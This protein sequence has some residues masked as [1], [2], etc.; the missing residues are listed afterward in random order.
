MGGNQTWT[1]NS[2]NL[3]TVGAAVT[4]IGN[5]TPY[6]LTV[7]GSG[8]TSFSG[9]ISNGGTTGTTALTM[10]GTGTLTLSAANTYTATTTINSGTLNLNF[11]AAGAPTSNIISSSSALAMSGGTLNITGKANV[12]NV[13]QNFAGLT[14]YGGA[15]EITVA[16]NAT[17]SKVILNLTS[18]TR[19]VGGTVNFNLPIAGG[20]GQNGG[21][22]ITETN[23]SNTNGILG[24][25]ATVGGTDWAERTGGNILPLTGNGNYQP[26][27]STTLGASTTGNTDMTVSGTTTLSSGGIVNSI[28]F[29]N[30]AA[31]TISIGSSQTVTVSSGGILETS[32]VGNFTNTISGG[33]LKGASANDLVVIQNNTSNNLTISSVI[34]NNGTSALTKS[35]ARGARPIWR[36]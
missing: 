19:N 6:T 33:T 20:Q 14:L 2:S 23:V 21:N 16:N 13:G 31:D 22:G 34:A 30:G 10:A 17:N 4:N 28:R 9:I 1:N 26:N 11:S 29:N 15:N 12:T 8:D 25:W 36:K 18:L 35:G 27:T 24:G 3:F 32:I 7:N 5:T